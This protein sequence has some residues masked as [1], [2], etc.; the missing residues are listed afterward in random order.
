M[1]LEIFALEPA[2]VQAHYLGFSTTIGADYIHY[3]IT[4]RVHAP[5]ENEKYYH[6]KL[7]LL[8]DTFMATTH[9]GV[10]DE[11]PSRGGCG[12]PEGAFVFANFNSHYKFDP[13]LFTIWMRL[14]RRVPGSVMWFV[15]GTPTS[16]DNLRREAEARGIAPER[17]IFAEK[18]V[19]GVHLARHRHVDLDGLWHSEPSRFFA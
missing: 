2:P 19:H 3:L 9:S 18:A 13:W 15:A 8:P 4:D 14:L 5:P 1:R 16:R 11:T 6:E 10:A 12:L 17:L 7:A